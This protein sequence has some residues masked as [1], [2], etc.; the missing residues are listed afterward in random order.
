MTQAYLYKWTEIST[1]KWYIG[2]RS[3]KNCH[4]NDGYICSSKIVKPKIKSNFNNWKREILCIGDPKYIIKLET[5]Y[6]KLLNAANDPMSYNLHNGD[7]NFTSLGY[8]PSELTRK[9][10]SDSHKGKIAWNKGIPMSLEMKEK[11]LQANLGKKKSPRTKEHAL[12][13]GSYHRG[14]TP[15]NKG[16]PMSEET[17]QKIRETKRLKIIEGK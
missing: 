4:P 5:D 3:K 15:W 11:L 8:C 10:M 16:K 12:K 9:K 7:G 2:S 1:N 6:L 17:K 13:I 14:K